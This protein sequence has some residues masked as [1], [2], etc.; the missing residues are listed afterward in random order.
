MVTAPCLPV[1]MCLYAKGQLQG[2]VSP[3]RSRVY[4]LSLAA[5]NR[6]SS[7]SNEPEVL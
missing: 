5:D 2:A 4:G 6:S 1:R 3:V 7:G